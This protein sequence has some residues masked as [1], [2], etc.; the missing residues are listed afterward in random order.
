MVNGLNLRTTNL[1]FITLAKLLDQSAICFTDPVLCLI[2][3]QM[4]YT[5][6]SSVRAFIDR[7]HASI[8]DDCNDANYGRYQRMHASSFRRFL[9]WR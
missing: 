2:L 7:L 5:R 9:S 8:I 1:N 4:R 6:M 3:C